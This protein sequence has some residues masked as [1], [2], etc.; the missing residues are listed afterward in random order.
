MALKLLGL[1]AEYRQV[2]ASSILPVIEVNALGEVIVDD[3]KRDVDV[4]VKDGYQEYLFM[5]FNGD[6]N[7]GESCCVVNGI[8]YPAYVGKDHWPDFVTVSALDLLKKMEQ[9]G[10][11]VRRW[12]RARMNKNKLI[13]FVPTDDVQEIP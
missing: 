8:Y 5:D 4:R 2:K 1:K 3:P 9:R 7:W 11:M 12:Y 13:Y 6:R 10:F